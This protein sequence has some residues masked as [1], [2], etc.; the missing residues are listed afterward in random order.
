MTNFEDGYYLYEYQIEKEDAI[1]N[2]RYCYWLS[3]EYPGGQFKCKVIDFEGVQHAFIYNKQ[4]PETPQIA[5][6]LQTGKTF[7]TATVNVGVYGK[8]PEKLVTAFREQEPVEH[9]KDRLQNTSET[10][11]K[12]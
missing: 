5:L 9:I 12:E 2:N 3:R 4:D 11:R 6:N 8:I 1:H 10:N 7:D